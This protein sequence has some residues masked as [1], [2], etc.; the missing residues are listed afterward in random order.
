MLRSRTRS[1]GS[2]QPASPQQTTVSP[3]R[4]TRLGMAGVANIFIRMRRFENQAIKPHHIV[5]A[6]GDPRS[7]PGLAESAC[8]KKIPVEWVDNFVCVGGVNVA[9]LLRATR[10]TLLDQADAL[11][12]NALVDEQWKCTICG[13]KHRPNGTFKVQIRYT[14]CATRSSQLDPHR[15]ITLDQAKGVPGLMTIIK[16]N[17]N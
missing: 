3:E 7:H 14:A 9:T 17:D 12:A 15:P 5:S 4:K 13:P 11:G 10:G 8:E 1:S 16:R 6:S 2:S